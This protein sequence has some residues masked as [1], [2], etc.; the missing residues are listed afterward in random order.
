MSQSREKLVTDRRTNERTDG[1]TDGRTD[2][3]TTV[4]LKDLR[5]RSKKPKKVTKIALISVN[6]TFHDEIEGFL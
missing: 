6:P 2:E 4:N 5:G 1:R 3:R